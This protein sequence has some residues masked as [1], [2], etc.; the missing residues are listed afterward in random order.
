MNSGTSPL[1]TM[2]QVKAL[3]QAHGSKLLSQLSDHNRRLVALEDPSP[4][5]DAGTQTTN[6]EAERKLKRKLSS[7]TKL[8]EKIYRERKE[9]GIARNGSLPSDLYQMGLRS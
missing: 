2:A 9:A 8:N 4:G 7:E 3:L 5:V 6:P 1:V